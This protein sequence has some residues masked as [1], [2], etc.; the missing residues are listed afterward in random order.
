MTRVQPSAAPLPLSHTKLVNRTVV[1]AKVGKTQPFSA[2]ASRVA[3]PVQLECCPA[4]S[5]SHSDEARGRNSQGRA[6]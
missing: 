3:G 6:L 1:C 5:K 4:P 2:L